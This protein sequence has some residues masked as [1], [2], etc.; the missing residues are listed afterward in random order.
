V[1]GIGTIHGFRASKPGERDLGRRRILPR[2]DPAEQ[3]HYS[4]IR[5]AGLRR[6]ARERVAEVGTV[7]R[8]F[9]VDLAR[10]EAL[11]QRAERHEANA[12]FLERRQHFLLG[13]PRPERV[14]ALEGGDR[15]DRVRAADRLR[16]GLG[17][18]EVPDLAC[19]DQ[20]FILG[21]KRMVQPAPAV[22]AGAG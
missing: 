21:V 17:K 5:F 2:R 12:E 10:E 14:F 7:E 1:P 13:I 11:A 15:L 3:I 9:F 6:E 8:G 16:A 4:L 20:V 18:A 22:R 19:A